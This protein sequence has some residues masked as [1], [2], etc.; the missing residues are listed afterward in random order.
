MLYHKTYF[1]EP[2]ADWVVFVHGA[3]GSSAVWFKQ[4]KAFRIH[5]NVLLIDLRGHGKSVNLSESTQ[6]SN[7]S[8]ELIAKDIIEV[9]DHLKIA[10]AHFIGVSL[11]TLIIR[12]LGD[13][14][15]SRMRT[16]ILVGA[17]THFNLKS[18]FWV[19][20]GRMFKNVLPYMWLY[21]LFAFV[22]MPAKNHAES[23][24]VFV[25]EAQKLCQREFLRW[26]K[27]TGQL[28]SLFIKFQVHLPI[29][30]LY[31]MGEQDYMFLDPIKKMIKDVQSAA[32]LV[33]AECGH[34][35]NIEKAQVFND[36]VIEYLLSYKNKSLIF[37][38]KPL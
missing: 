27:L 28:S 15:G 12:Q 38:T 9:L 5:F 23:R 4:L 25:K 37:S 26:Y 2:K 13:M 16:M 21:R 24:N 29:P 10:E 30:T 11:G 22:I 17:I 14:I 34:V 19:G 6:H 7:Y 20:L 33:V 36:E 1:L 8:F 3:G 31:V 35:V 18:R 32:L